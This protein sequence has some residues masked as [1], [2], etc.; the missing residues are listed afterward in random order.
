MSQFLWPLIILILFGMGCLYFAGYPWF[1]FPKIR[2]KY[3]DPFFETFFKKY[4]PQNKG[5]NIILG[6]IYMFIFFSFTAFV[7]LILLSLWSYLCGFTPIEGI[8]FVNYWDYVIP[9]FKGVL[10]I[11]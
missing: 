11:S 9:S 2:K 7:S 8:P 3:L 5:F 4:F 6:L 10:D 1:V